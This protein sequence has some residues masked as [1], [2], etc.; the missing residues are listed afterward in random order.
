MKELVSR[1]LD[2]A[3]VLGASYADIRILRQKTEV[4]TVKNGTVEGVSKDEDEGFGVRVLANGA[5]GFASS[6]RLEPGEIDRVTA[7]AVRVARASA[8]AKRAEVRLGPAVVSRGSYSTTVRIDPFAI[9]MEDKIAL[10]LRADAAMRSVKGVSL[11]ESSLEFLAIEKLFASSEG[12]LVEQHL[13]E[14]GGGI[15]ATAVAD[16]E[17]QKRSHPNSFGRQQGTAGFEFILDMKLEENAPRIAEEA[18][19]LLTAEQCPSDLVTTLILDPTQLA[20]QLHESCGHPIELDRVM[21]MESSYAGTSF[22]T[23]DKMG[24]FRYGSDIVNIVADATVLGG[25]GTFGYD[26]EGVPAQQVPIVQNGIF[27]NYLT[28]RET[29][30]DLGQQSNGTMRADGWNRI[31]LI[32]MT[33][34]NLEPGPWSFEELIADTD[35]GIYMQTNKSWSIDDRRLNFQ[36]GTEVAWEIRGGKRGRMFKNA[37]YTGITPEFWGGCDAICREW[38]VWGTPNCGKG[39]PPQVAHVGH[40]AAAARFRNVRVGVMR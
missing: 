20:L 31:P 36:F 7:L 3:R 37:T 27:L 26:D 23:L 22:L 38:N 4:I 10:L 6:Y 15:E 13:V 9:S 25:L 1:A 11:A 14:S 12:S 30:A 29:A 33:N 40:G 39:E 28:S 35:D 18:V 8:L 17:V 21:G 2:L 16:G 24:G 19:R 34:I 5:W 32:R